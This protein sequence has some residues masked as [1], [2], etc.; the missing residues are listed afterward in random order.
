MK[1]RTGL[2]AVTLVT[3]LMARPAGAQQGTEAA[4]PAS[5]KATVNPDGDT[6]APDEGTEAPAEAE[7]PA[8]EPAPVPF[9]N[10]D[11]GPRYTIEQVVV[12]GNRKTA[13]A[14]ILG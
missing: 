7:P 13:A 2:A 4:E 11:F 6:E 10:P 8:V 3:A 5:A 1:L 9:G 12:R 14:L